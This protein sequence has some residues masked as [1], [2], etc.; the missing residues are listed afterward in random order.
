MFKKDKRIDYITYISNPAI[1]SRQVYPNPAA[2]S[3]VYYIADKIAAA[4][5]VQIVTFARSTIS[6]KRFPETVVN[7]DHRVKFKALRDA[8]PQNLILHKLY[9]LNWHLKAFR[10]LLCHNKE[11]TIIAYHSLE[12]AF[13][14]WIAKKI[15]GFKLILEL[16]EIYQDVVDC[17]K[18]KAYWERKVISSADAYILATEALSKQIPAGR[19]YIVIN[20]TYR[21]EP[22]RNVRFDDDKIHCVYAGTFDPTKGGAAA[23]AAA[24]FLP[25]NYHVHILGFGTDEQ[26]E[27][28]KKQI[29]EVQKTTKCTLTYD[30]LKSGE[31]YIQFLQKCHI[32]LCTQVP[33]AKYTETSF[34]SKVLVYLANGLR[35]LSVRIP[36]V[37]QS[38]VGDML[39]YY[40]EQKPEKIAEAIQS[41]DV[42][43]P[44]DSRE[45][46]N[47][48]DIK[49]FED[50][51][52]LL[53]SENERKDHGKIYAGS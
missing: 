52:K 16:E 14:L 28:L 45:R 8:E 23:A 5:S 25:Q 11:D 39:F 17:S 47:A 4:E 3:K 2:E 13:E 24:A 38:D 12:D 6:G 7:M 19:P 50:I 51:E 29:A 27:N 22:P 43:L 35:V 30:G 33:D 41:I 21:S 46:L 40:D 32:G 53:D 31:E 36:A 42:T 9:A 26:I 37:K 48:L 18:D 44:Y 49:A 15:C 1:K 10:E 20:G 34:P